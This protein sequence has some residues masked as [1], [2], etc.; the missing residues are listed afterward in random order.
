VVLKK[1]YS[2]EKKIG[3]HTAFLADLPDGLV[4]DTIHKKIYINKQPVTHDDLVTQSATVEMM[5]KVCCENHY[6]NPTNNKDLQ[7]SSYSKNKNDMTGKII[8]PLQK[9]VEKTYQKKLLL[10]CS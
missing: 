4:F 3:K 5:E 2:H 7:A 9:L 10:E 1:C 6:E 8:L